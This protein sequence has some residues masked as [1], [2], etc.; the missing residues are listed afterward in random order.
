VPDRVDALVDPVEPP[1]REAAFD[2]AAPHPKSQ[3]LLVGDDAV[4]LCRERGQLPVGW[5]T[6][7]I[8]MTVFVDQV[9]RVPAAVLHRGHVGDEGVTRL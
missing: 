4:L 6:F 5:S 1:R 8:Y 7:F 2:R 3:Q 9:A